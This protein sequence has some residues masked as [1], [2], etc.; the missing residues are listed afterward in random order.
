MWKKPF[1][2]LQSFRAFQHLNVFRFHFSDVISS[3]FIFLFFCVWET[4]F[5]NQIESISTYRKQNRRWLKWMSNFFHF[6][7]FDLFFSSVF[8]SIHA[9]S[10]SKHWR[11]SYIVA[12]RHSL[13]KICSK[14]GINS[15]LCLNAIRQTSKNLLSVWVC[16]FSLFFS[17]FVWLIFSALHC[18]LL[19]ACTIHYVQSIVMPV[20]K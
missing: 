10:C 15:C 13:N 8:V 9:V 2:T 16:V 14:I 6:A 20:V 11:Q 17:Y 5:P 1:S 3:P 18:L 7:I 12:V 19:Y 4:H